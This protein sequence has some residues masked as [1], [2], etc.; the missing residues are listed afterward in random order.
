MYRERRTCKWFGSKQNMIT[1][2]I[3]MKRHFLDQG[4]S[5]ALACVGVKQLCP[6]GKDVPTSGHEEWSINQKFPHHFSRFTYFIVVLVILGR[7]VKS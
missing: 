6:L 5:A 7:G 1:A 2:K 3:S 4:T